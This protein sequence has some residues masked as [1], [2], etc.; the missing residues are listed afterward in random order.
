MFI[1]LGYR[2]IILV[3]S[4]LSAALVLG[5][6]GGGGGGGDANQGAGGSGKFIDSAVEGLTYVSGATTAKTDA[7]GTFNNGDSKEVTFKVG[8]VVLGKLS[9]KGI[10]TPV[11]L[12]AGATDENNDTV[13][14]IAK[15]LQTI[16]DDNNPSNGIK[17]SAAADA[18]AKGKTVNFAQTTAAFDADSSVQSALAAITAAT[19]AG[20]HSPVT[21]ANAKSHLK[22]SLLARYAG[23]YSGTY[24]GSSSGTYTVT[25][26]NNGTISGSGKEGNDGFSI[27]G[28][29]KS[30]GSAT[31]ASGIAGGATFS[32]T[33]NPDT[34]ALSGTWV[35]ASDASFKGT[36]TGAKQ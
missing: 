12:V 14:N 10:V 19:A 8:D 7:A 23:T 1:K 3:A 24:S 9:P 25:V 35:S 6:C 18:A 17:I 32:G 13:A 26:N 30:N 16:D 4:S 20:A 36:F 5:A 15:F 31:L 22:A 28:S 33:I 11:D 27:T 29:I 2:K 34:G 21:T